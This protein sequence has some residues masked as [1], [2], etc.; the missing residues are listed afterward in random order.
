MASFE[1][2]QVMRIGSASPNTVAYYRLDLVQLCQDTNNR[3][4]V[5]QNDKKTN[6]ASVQLTGAGHIHPQTIKFSA[7]PENSKGN[8]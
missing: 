6:D 8:V 2:Y 4:Y 5:E 3:S 7:Y 1:K